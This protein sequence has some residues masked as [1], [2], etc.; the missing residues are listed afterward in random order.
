MPSLTGAVTG[1]GMPLGRLTWSVIEAGRYAD[2]KAQKEQA[3]A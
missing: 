1:D 3:K 2:G